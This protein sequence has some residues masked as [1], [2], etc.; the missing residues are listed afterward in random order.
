MFYINLIA[1]IVVAAACLW[2]VMCPRVNDGWFGKFVFMALCLAA[3]AN[4]AWAWQYKL[5]MMHSE[6]L[7]NLAA[8]CVA[9]RC[10]WIKRH[11]AGFRRFCRRHPCKKG[12]A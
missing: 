12:K 8:A 10:Y 2:A 9:L 5:H 11:R 6:V 4:A 7:F 1:N 3:S